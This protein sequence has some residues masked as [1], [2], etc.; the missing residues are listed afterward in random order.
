MQEELEQNKGLFKV[1]REQFD[2]NKEFDQWFQANDCVSDEKI[3]TFLT[4]LNRELEMAENSD[5]DRSHYS[6]QKVKKYMEKG[7]K[8]DSKHLVRRLTLQAGEVD[9][10]KRAL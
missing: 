6:T 5:S 1:L 2:I 10:Y 4:S 3:K 9:L 7:E 8:F